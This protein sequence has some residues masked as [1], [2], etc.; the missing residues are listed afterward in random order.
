MS[1]ICN[2]VKCSKQSSNNEF[3]VCENDRLDAW[4]EMH[5]MDKI[6]GIFVIFTVLVVLLTLLY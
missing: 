5:K 1:L 6:F 3:D 2:C 4:V